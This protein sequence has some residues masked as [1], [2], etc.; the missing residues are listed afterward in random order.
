MQ[1]AYSKS[2]EKRSPGIAKLVANINL[3]SDDVGEWVFKISKGEKADKVISQWVRKN[4]KRV[5]S[6]LG[7]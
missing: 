6:W 2:L 5:D 3:T 7:L 4:S 1:I